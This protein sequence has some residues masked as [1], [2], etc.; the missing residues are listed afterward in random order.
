VLM[1]MRAILAQTKVE[2]RMQ[3]LARG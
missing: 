3:R 2:A 1:R